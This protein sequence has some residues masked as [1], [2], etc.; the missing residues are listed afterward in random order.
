[1]NRAPTSEGP[2]RS[3]WFL[4]LA[5]GLLAVGLRLWAIDL[6]P[7]GY[8]EV[9]VLSRARAVL[10]G[11]PTATGPLT[12]WGIPD[13]PV[14]V[15]LMVPPSALPRPALAAASWGALLNVAAVVL[16]YLLAHRHFGPWMG[17]SAGL[18][19]ATN[20]WAVYFS[21]RTWAEITPLFTVLALWGAYEVICCRRAR[22]AVLFCVALALQVQTRILALVYGP[23]ALLTV[24]LFPLRW[25]ARWPALGV[26]LGA[27][28]SLPFL[29]YLASHW[30]ELASK[31]GEGNRGIAL[32][33]RYL[34]APELL[35]WTASGYA[36]LP[37]V[38][39]AAPWL[40]P[41]GLAGRATLWLVG[42]LFAAG[43]GMAVWAVVTRRPGSERL[44]VLVLWLVLPL[45]MLSAQSSSVYL[46][47]MVAV[48][49]AMFL[50]MALPLGAALGRGRPVTRLIAA[51]ALL[52]VCGVQLTT[53]GAL[54]RIMAAYE[55][56]DQGA[57]LELR[58]AAAALPRE[59]SEQ[60]GTGER[61]GVEVPLRFWETLG[62]R[63]RAEAARA[64]LGEIWVLAGA[65]DPLT[66]ER[67]AILDY[68]LRPSLEPHFLPS[69]TLV[70]PLGQPALFLEAPDVDPPEPLDRFGA[71]RANI[72]IPST[73]RAGRDSA[74]L[75]LVEP[76]SAEMWAALVPNRSDAAFESDV[77]LR[78][79]RSARATRAG[80]DLNAVTYW[81]LGP[82]A[83]AAVPQ[84]S[85]RLVDDG[86]RR[87]APPE[88]QGQPP[89]ATPVGDRFLIRRQQLTIPLRVAEGEYR[90]EAL[91]ADAHGRPIH[92]LDGAGDAV[93]L[94]P[95]RVAA[96]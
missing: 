64:G 32:V 89:P 56:D 59:A 5:I 63:S 79:Y 66:A 87:L 39:K 45:L 23:A 80:D 67:P 68:V 7:F 95:V 20:P 65:A 96:R 18:L 34:G 60:L 49:P 27:V 42:V 78:G 15:Y 69:D 82:E 16:A 36:L 10:D 24:I 30:P 73:N 37:A 81:R 70:F 9:D 8:D 54:Y 1:M 92:R 57:S 29:A 50:V 35:L 52:W 71:R 11:Q 3:A 19:Y 22:W 2:G 21:R 41:L 94:T 6:A 44:V 28:L 13:P 17:L 72:P 74:R 61:Y 55:R 48:F 26:G 4:S 53:T 91:L 58:Q 43:L 47:Y 84:V 83:P 14:S 33:P 85:V 38:S 75:T 40:N 90:L 51:A 31:L 88:R 86:G 62:D 12:S 76:R 93:L 46:H 25:G 77:Q